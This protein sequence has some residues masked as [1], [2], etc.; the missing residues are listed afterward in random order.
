M[1]TVASIIAV[2]MKDVKSELRARYTMNALLMFVVVSVAT[3]LF[4]LHE[5]E[6]NPEILSGM[7][8]IVIFFSAMSGLS[9]IFVS[10]EERGTTMTLQ[11]IA[12]PTAVYFGKLIFNATL[13]LILS[14]AVTILYLLAFP[15]FLIKSPNIFVLTLLLGSVGFAAAATIIAAIIAKAS[16]KGI[17]YP[18]LSFPVLLP[19]LVTVMK[20]TAR[21]LD[22]EVFWVAFGDFQ[23]LIAYILVM[24][25]GSYLLFGYVWR[26]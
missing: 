22:G 7:F 13:A 17:L 11:L 2:V 15:A 4:A 24:T 16:A 21:A 10:E 25:A 23:M 5:D 14:T 26:D 18:V 12:S 20:A 9:R 8:W 3:I 19:L 1:T 6:L